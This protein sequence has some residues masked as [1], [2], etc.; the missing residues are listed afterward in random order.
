M[1]QKKFLSLLLLLTLLLFACQAQPPAQD[2]NAPAPTSASNNEPA[3]AAASSSPTVSD[4][5]GD[6]IV[7]VWGGTTEE[8]IRN[9]VEPKFLKLYPN[10]NVVYDVGGMS[11]R[12]N[13][14]LAQKDS[15]EI[16]LFFSTSEIALAAVR[17]GLVVPINRDNI[18][19]M[20]GLYDWALPV[21]EYGAAFSGIAYGLA[22]NP[23]FFGD[24]LPTSWNDLWRPEV[25]DKIAVPGIGHSAMPSF[26]VTAAK[27][28]GGGVDNVEP[29]FEYL[30][31]L[32]PV[33]QTFFYTDWN[34]LYD[35]SD[36]VLATEFDY[37]VNEMA[38][39]GINIRFLIPKEGAFGSTQHVTI[40]KG[41]ENQEAA[42]AFLN[43]MLSKEMQQSVAVDLLNAPSRRDIDI[44][45]EIAKTL[46]LVGEDGNNSENSD[47][48]FWLDTAL[49]VEKR[50]EWTERMNEIVAPAWG[51]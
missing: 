26:I 14:L 18:P 50:A 45:P 10:V 42:E 19:N 38:S 2:S 3:D 34:A 22:Y 47:R 1:S 25:Q 28:N 11:A 20:E 8:W 4:Y 15:P 33:A 6:L 51:Q 44:P 37:Y 39:S 48:I 36:V 46:A 13:K 49:A 23:D 27:L 7:S 12:Y 24:N 31:K 21:P 43:I 40:V 9:F 41:T 32:H 17:E 16:D 29:G 5:K 35:A 30:A